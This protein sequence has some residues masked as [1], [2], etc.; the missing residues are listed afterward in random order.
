MADSARQKTDKKLAQIERQIDRMYRKA[1]KGIV[2]KWNEYLVDVDKQIS[3]LQAEYEAAKANGDKETTKKLG[4]KLVKLKRDKTLQNKYY[5]QMVDHTA[6]QITIANQRATAYI[7]GEIP[8]VYTWNY[9][10]VNK[11]AQQYGIRFD[12]RDEHTVRRLFLNGELDLLPRKINE[13]KDVAWNK[14][15]MNSSVLQGILQGES[16]PKIA[17]RIMPIVNNNKR[18]AVSNARTMITSAECGG[19]L[20][21]Y[22]DLTK[23]GAIMKKVWIATPDD[24]TRKSHL[25]IDGEEQNIEDDFTNGCAFPGDGKGPADE[26]W[27]CRCSMKAHIIGIRGKYGKI[28]YAKEFEDKSLH[29]KQIKEE[30]ERR[31]EE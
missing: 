30:R 20:D 9:N 7:N 6:H 24:R 13:G 28:R 26:V 10:Y 2:K 31:E 5:Q 21:S 4:I 22:R 23:N 27:Q 19:R 1:T 8:Q 3:T 15:Q 29:K 17:N 14:K 12:I 18:S 11:E 16:I 25:D